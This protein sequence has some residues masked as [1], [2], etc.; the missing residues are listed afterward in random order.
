V[1]DELTRQGCIVLA[2]FTRKA[3]NSLSVKLRIERLSE[4]DE[5]VYD[6]DGNH[7]NATPISGAELDLMHLA[8][9]EAA[10]RV[11]VVTDFAHHLVAGEE[12]AKHET[13]FYIGESTRNEIRHAHDFDIPVE[14]ARVERQDYRDTIVWLSP[15]VGTKLAAAFARA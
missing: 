7:L 15:A 14:F 8:K 12:A 6:P 3:V 9:I 2:P 5:K 10:D 4:R 11:V 1:A 13:G